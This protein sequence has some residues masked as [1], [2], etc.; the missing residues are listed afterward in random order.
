MYI[1]IQHFVKRLLKTPLWLWVSTSWR[2]VSSSTQPLFSVLYEWKVSRQ[3]PASAAM[4]SCFERLN[5]LRTVSQIKFCL[6]LILSGN[7]IWKQLRKLQVVVQFMICSRLEK[8]KIMVHGPKYPIKQKRLLKKYISVV[9]V[10]IYFTEKKMRLM[11][12]SFLKL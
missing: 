4:S 10:H 5:P 1:I 6:K 3:L 8:S 9:W 11:P 7:F 2:F 12:I